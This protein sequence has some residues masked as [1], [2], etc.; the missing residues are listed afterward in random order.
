[1]LIEDKKPVREK[2]IWERMV[3]N[4]RLTEEEL[5]QF[6]LRLY[7]SEG[8]KP[9]E[10]Y[11]FQLFEVVVAAI[12]AR[13]KPDYSW[14][15]TPRGGDGGIDFVGRYTFLHSKFLD[16]EAHITIGGQCK[17]HERGKN[18]DGSLLAS[19][20]DMQDNIDPHLYLLVVSSNMTKRNLEVL[21]RRL[22]KIATHYSIFKRPD[23]CAL[24]KYN[25]NISYRIFD[26]AL[27]KED[28]NKVRNYFESFFVKKDIVEFTAESPESVLA[29]EVFFV[30]LHL[31]SP[32]LNNIEIRVC[33]N[34]PN[35]DS[36]YITLVSPI[37]IDSKAGAKV[38]FQRG[39]LI[40]PIETELT[41]E[42]L[43]YDVGKREMGSL[44][45][46]IEGVGI[47]QR[48]E[49]P[50]I[51]VIENLRPHFYDEPY[52]EALAEI[53][54]FRERAW[55][56]NVECLGVTGAGGSGK[57]R[58]CEEVCLEGRRFGGGIVSARQ[59]NTID[60]P[61]RILAD[62]LLRLCEGVIDNQ[63]S[64]ESVISI[65]AK[66]NCDL[67]NQSKFAIES[68][69]GNAGKA[70]DENDMAILLKVYTLLIATKARSRPLIIHLH[71]LHWCMYEILEFI[72]KIIWQL[73]HINDSEKRNSR[74][75]SIL[76]LLEGRKHEYRNVKT[77][78]STLMYERFLKNLDCCVVQCPD[79]SE[80]QSEIFSLRVFEAAHSPNRKLPI[81]LINIQKEVARE[82]ARI[83]GSNPFHLLEHIKYLQQRGVLG[84]NPRTG[85]IYLKKITQD[86]HL[87]E[88]VYACIQARWEYI[89]THTKE[90]AVLIWATGLVDDQVPKSLFHHLWAT[91]APRTNLQEINETGF[92]RLGEE[93]SLNTI[94][95]FRHENYFQGLKTIQLDAEEREAI[96]RCYLNWFSMS[97]GLSPRMQLMRARTELSSFHPNFKEAKVILKKAQRDASKQQDH[98]LRARILGVLLDEIL[99]P[100]NSMTHV[101]VQQFIAICKYE[102][103]LADLLIRTGHR[104]LAE[105]RIR[106]TLSALQ[107]RLEEDRE[108]IPIVAERYS[109]V[110]FELTIELIRAAFNN[111]HPGTAEEVAR[112]AI[113][114]LQAFCKLHNVNQSTEWKVIEIELYHVHSVALALSGRLSEAIKQSRYAFKLAQELP[115]GFPQFVD[116]A[117]TYANILLCED[118]DES[119]QLLNECLQKMDGQTMQKTVLLKTH[120]HRAMT[121]LLIAYRNKQSGSD[122][123]HDNF[124]DISLEL[125]NVY[126]MAQSVGIVADAAAAALLLGILHA[127]KNSPQELEWS[128]RAV[129]LATYS[130]QTETLWRAHV[131]LAH[132][133]SRNGESPRNSAETALDI[134]FESLSEYSSPDSSKRYQMIRIPLAHA[135]SYLLS[136]DDR[137]G[138]VIL[139]KIPDLRTLF[140][141]TSKGT[142]NPNRKSYLTHEHID[143]EDREYIIY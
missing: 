46:T 100:E 132:G 4:F 29:G 58:L 67:A 47:S 76:F 34:K 28:Y 111:Q 105:L 110:R 99:W 119:L 91:I 26:K 87:P 94:V 60:Y 102:V 13:M 82:I 83:S 24:I 129:A 55:A 103:E 68:L 54:Y 11:S 93:K 40:L 22:K 121:R 79:F 137:K 116:V 14:S 57:S 19:V 81:S 126:S 61:R 88:S 12:F 38:H 140:E 143:I 30:N 3:Y 128:A 9:Q 117:S 104:G 27:D 141:D 21:D 10:S 6:G 85:L 92:L 37:E 15:V 135:V 39:D 62:L 96:V 113:Y 112:E 32:L 142:L 86:L 42:F 18:V 7:L 63:I 134:L 16:I 95:T 2:E 65:V 136:E 73:G 124:S 74:R 80:R 53:E 41:L 33:W 118:L 5:E 139:Q 17:K 71:D 77:E 51:D 66:L 72:D 8:K 115:D 133:L 123:S 131:N 59:N 89:F 130:R 36:H 98:S 50:V 25:S 44:S 43:S 108:T 31:R 35:S 101:R 106:N 97:K 64:A 84:Q 1:M 20:A 90:V 127:L 52:R 48:I 78:W 114:H 70:A 69:I 23:I 109:L 122:L 49:L 75:L 45:I 125:E 107:K 138:E 120:L 56:G